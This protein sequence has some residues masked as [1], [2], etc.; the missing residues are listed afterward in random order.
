[1]LFSIFCLLSFKFA[2]ETPKT[3]AEVPVNETN[4]ENDMA[5]E[6]QVF[7]YFY[8]SSGRY[9]QYCDSLYTKLFDVT[10]KPSRKVFDYAMK[11]YTYFASQGMLGRQDVLSFID[12]SLSS[13]A[14][15]FWVID[16]KQVK[17]LYHELVAHGRNTGSEFARKFSNK[18]NSFQT[19]IGFFITGEIYNGKHELS[20]K[21]NGM[22]RMYNSNALDRGIVIH[23]ADYVSQEYIQQNQRLGR[24]LGCPAVRQE[25]IAS[26]SSTIS[27]GTCVFAYYPHKTYLRNSRV[28]K[29]DVVFA[30]AK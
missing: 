1:M 18:A 23:G 12:Y 5:C 11:G 17:V 24:S 14:R 9:K 28:L 26:L 2:E 13:N 29:S 10:N 27:G 4:R 3:P 25:V 6:Q 15:R 22:E 7:E 21:M 30:L 16:L 8:T 20:V 19:S